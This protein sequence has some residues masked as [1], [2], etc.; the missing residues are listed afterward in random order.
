MFQ[1][2]QLTALVI[3]G[4]PAQGEEFT[5]SLDCVAIKKE[6]V[7][8]VLPC[9]QD[10]VGSRHF[11]QTNFVSE[12]GLAMLS[13]SVA[14]ADSITSSPVYAPW[15]VVESASVSQVITDLCACWDWV[16]CVVALPKTKVSAGITVAPLGMR[17]FQGQG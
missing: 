8:G 12:T 11:I 6:E 17:Q 4:P 15:S 7:R 16:V 1:V 5:I 2:F 10:F 9:V 14:I 3:R 13:E